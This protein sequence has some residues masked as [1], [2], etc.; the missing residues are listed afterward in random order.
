L[1]TQREAKE[2]EAEDRE[3]EWLTEQER[4]QLKQAKKEGKR[5]KQGSIAKGNFTNYRNKDY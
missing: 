2:L 5:K 1:I 4:E 3:A